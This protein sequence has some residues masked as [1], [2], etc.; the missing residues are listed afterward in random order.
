MY[1]GSIYAFIHIY[2]HTHIYI[3]ISIYYICVIAG[4]HFCFDTITILKE[5]RYFII[6]FY[7]VL[8]E[9]VGI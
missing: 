7:R 1:I 9:I 8:L 4:L 5:F 6:N 2:T 3:H